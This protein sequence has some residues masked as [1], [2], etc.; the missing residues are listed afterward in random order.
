MV[1]AASSDAWNRE[2]ATF[3]AIPSSVRETPSKA[4][5][6]L[7]NLIQLPPHFNVLDLG[8]GNGR[9]SLF[10]AELGGEVH[11]VDFS[12]AAASETHQ[13]VL[14]AN[15]SDRVHVYHQSFSDA[16]PLSSGS[17]D[18]VLDAYVLCH[19]LEPADQRAYVNLARA[20]VRD[21][22]RILEPMPS[23]VETM[24]GFL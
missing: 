13:R 18:I 12:S 15:V 8:C 19:F 3:Q 24:M 14:R 11:A 21:S 2:Y 22:G 5:L 23:Q 9:N 6:L 20:M 17:F 16:L 1:C 7:A 4:V 10:F